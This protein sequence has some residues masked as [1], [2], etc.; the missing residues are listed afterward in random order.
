M[1]LFK[2]TS[3]LLTNFRH[4]SEINLKLGMHI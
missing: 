2:E 3:Y 1:F 4:E